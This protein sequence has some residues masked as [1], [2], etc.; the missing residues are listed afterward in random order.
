MFWNLSRMYRP[1]QICTNRYLQRS[2]SLT[3]LE[4]CIRTEG[5]SR[6]DNLVNNLSE[7][8]YHALALK[9]HS[10]RKELVEIALRRLSTHQNEHS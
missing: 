3:E 1:N 8:D 6:I 5:P 7:D 10:K 4:C 2:S 9:L